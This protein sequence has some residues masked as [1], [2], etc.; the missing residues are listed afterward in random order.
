MRKM[1]IIMAIMLG[2]QLFAQEVPTVLNGI[3][4]DT[5]TL[6]TDS[7]EEFTAFIVEGDFKK[8]A[9][10]IKSYEINNT[11]KD[12]NVK[13]VF[14]RDNGFEFMETRAF[15]LKSVTIYKL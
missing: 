7:G 14:R 12:E 2:S 3:D 4:Y 8:L 11:V 6:T 10:Q 5:V 1:M 13:F 9:K 15:K